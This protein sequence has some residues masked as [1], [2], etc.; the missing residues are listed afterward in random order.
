MAVASQHALDRETFAKERSRMVQQ[1][2][3]VETSTT[4]M[5]T[6]QLL[7]PRIHLTSFTF[8]SFNKW[9]QQNYPGWRAVRREASRE[10][11]RQHR[12]F[13]Q[14]KSYFTDVV[15]AKGYVYKPRSMSNK[16]KGNDKET[17]DETRV[18]KVSR[19]NKKRKVNIPQN[20]AGP[21]LRL[22]P[23]LQI[24]CLQFLPDSCHLHW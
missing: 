20:L 2:E 14:G 17:K 12:A 8:R 21:F 4:T 11:R 10:E 24:H 19:G 15:Y 1:R 3:A 9:V 22:N 7:T 6:I 23:E 5:L 16:R 13:H 18:K